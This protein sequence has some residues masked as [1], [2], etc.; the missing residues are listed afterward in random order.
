MEGRKEGRKEGKKGE[1][2]KSLKNRAR[3]GRAKKRV[4]KRRRKINIRSQ[5]QGRVG[6]K[7][8]RKE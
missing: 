8:G 7:E 3:I 2:E 1:I 5:R 6:K 4:E